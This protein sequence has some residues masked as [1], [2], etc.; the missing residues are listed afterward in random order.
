[1]QLPGSFRR[2]CHPKKRPRKH[3]LRSHNNSNK[4]GCHPGAWTSQLLAFYCASALA[5]AL[6]KKLTMHVSSSGP[7]SRF[8]VLGCALTLFETSKHRG[9]AITSYFCCN[10]RPSS[11]RHATLTYVVLR[12][13][14][15]CSQ[16][17]ISLAGKLDF[18]LYDDVPLAQNINS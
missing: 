7:N 11:L 13:R 1:M 9:S 18:C 16:L 5:P 15:I 12:V 3:K 17:P 6:T 10:R 14:D 2:A 8:E 4:T